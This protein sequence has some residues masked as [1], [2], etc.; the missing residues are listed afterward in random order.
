MV[1]VIT[2]DQRESRRTPDLVEAVLARLAVV[3]TVLP[4]ERTAGD[5]FQGL[6]ADPLSVVAVSMA[7]VREG[8]W[9]VGIGAGEV[10]H[11]L[12]QASRAARGEAYSHAREAVEAAKHRPT[13]V[14]VRGAEAGA[15]QDAEAVLSLLAALVQRRTPQGWE[16]ADLM[17]QGLTATQAGERLGITRQAVGQRLAAAL[18]H[19]EQAARPAAARLLALAA[20]GRA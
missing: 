4:F 14:A 20:G 7:L 9:S 3:Q 5:E 11:P 6:L 19:E 13:R 8:T 12:P 18:W 16:A 1:F 2:A 17:A 15:A 10:E